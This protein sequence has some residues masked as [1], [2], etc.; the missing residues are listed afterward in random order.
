MIQKRK[1]SIPQ[2]F[3]ISEQEA[4]FLQKKMEEAGI[5]NKS[6]YFRKMALDGYIIRQDYAVLNKFIYELNRIGNNLNQMA[7]VANTY[8]TVDPSELKAVEKELDRI[9]QQLSSLG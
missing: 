2:L 1:R 4:R 7:K 5:R 6:A 8:G 9:W 3:F